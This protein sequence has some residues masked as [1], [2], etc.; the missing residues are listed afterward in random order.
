MR[1][2]DKL[3]HISC[4]ILMRVTT[5]MIEL[6]RLVRKMGA[7]DYYLMGT[8]SFNYMERN[9]AERNFYVGSLSVQQ[10]EQIVRRFHVSF[11]SKSC[12]SEQRLPAPLSARIPNCR[13]RQ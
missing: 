9:Y 13:V 6:D 5:S 11:V 1:V 12:I 7:S 4:Q 10:R 8:R 3:S 2:V